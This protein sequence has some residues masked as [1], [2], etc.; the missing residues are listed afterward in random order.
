MIRALALLLVCQLAGEVSPYKVGDYV[1]KSY[2]KATKVMA[3]DIELAMVAADHAFKAAGIKM[4]SGGW[5][6]DRL[7]QFLESDRIRNMDRA[8]AQRETLKALSRKIPALM[9]T[10]S[11]SEWKQYLRRVKVEGEL[12]AIQWMIQLHPDA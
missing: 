2:R 6:V 1:P 3:R 11:D 10:L 9:S 4:P 8:E 5:N 12:K 7:Q